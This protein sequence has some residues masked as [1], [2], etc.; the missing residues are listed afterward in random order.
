MRAFA[1]SAGLA[2]ALCWCAIFNASAQDIPLVFTAGAPARPASDAA[3]QAA[4]TI[5]ERG[6]AL[7]SGTASD[8]GVGVALST[9]GWT[10]RSIASIRMLPSDSHFRPAFQQIEIARTVLS[11]GSVSVAAGGGLREEWDGTRVLIGRVLAGA[12]IGRGRLQGSLVLE[13]FVAS[14]AKHDAAD[15][16]TTFGWSQRINNRVSAGVE[17]I[18]QDLEGLWNPAEADGGATLLAGPSLHIQSKSGHW[19]A[20]LVAGPVLRRP[21][22]DALAAPHPGGGGRFGMFASAT[23]TPSQH[24]DF[25]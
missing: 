14:P 25:R 19:A 7:W 17:G 3:P 9:A 2:L 8:F 13:R 23:W 6:L 21:S 1:R 20:S 4:A 11:A 15:V 10:I 24:R 18:G 12:D 5:E 16:V 22:A